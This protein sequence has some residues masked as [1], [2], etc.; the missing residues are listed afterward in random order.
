MPKVLMCPPDYYD[1]S[2]HINPWMARSSFINKDLA[3]QQWVGL[4]NQIQ[5]FL[6]L[7]VETIT[8]QPNLPDMVFTRDQGIIQDR[9]FIPANFTPPQRRGETDHY[10]RW[11]EKNDYTINQ[12]SSQCKFEGGDFLEWD[13]LL[14]GG[15][16][17]R[18]D[19]ESHIKLAR[20]TGFNLI[21]LELINPLFFHLDMALFPLGNG[22]LAY[23]PSAFSLSSR[24]I[25]ENLSAQI[26]HISHSDACDFSLNTLFYKSKILANHCTKYL[27]DM[28]D[29]LGYEVTKVDVSEFTKAGGGIHCLTLMV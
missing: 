12:I 6:G 28:L 5:D 16:G 21:S 1:I 17:F 23:Y 14:F 3:Y 22:V 11:F 13:G 25:L 27:S 4:K 15:C 2:Y 8:P 26:V 9:T 7:P 20:I 29:E 10:C 18:T 19:R 24:R